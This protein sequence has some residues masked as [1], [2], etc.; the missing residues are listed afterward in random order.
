MHLKLAALTHTYIYYY[1][2]PPAISY[3]ILATSYAHSTFGHYRISI[4]WHQYAMN[5]VLKQ[6]L[7]QID[8]GQFN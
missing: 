2:G 8:V 5:V 7:I 1:S 4:E 3:K 6:S